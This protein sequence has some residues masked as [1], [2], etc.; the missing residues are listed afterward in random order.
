[1]TSRERVKAILAREIPDRMAI[2]EHLWG[3][4]LALE[5][6]WIKDFCQVYL[7]FFR[8]HYDLIFSEAGK[9]DGVFIYITAG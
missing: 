1:M 8:A 2:H 7:D 4:T 9:P 6:E 3:Q 5:P